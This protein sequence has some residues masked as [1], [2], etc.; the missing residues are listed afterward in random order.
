MFQG[1]ARYAKIVGKPV[2]GFDP[3]EKNKVWTTDVVI[4]EATEAKLVQEGAPASQFKT[5]DKTG[6]RYITLKRKAYKADG[7][8][9]KP[10]KIKD[11]Q[12]RDWDQD[13]E[14]RPANQLIGNG[15]VLNVMYNINEWTFGKKKGMRVDPLAIQVWEHVKYEGGSQFP[16]A[17]K[18]AQ[19]KDNGGENWE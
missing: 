4:D 16:V 2:E 7:T 9:A 11:D 18:R 6:E 13:F 12:T 5:D 14:D 8:A 3:G 19:M 15:S 10:I 1:K 17:D